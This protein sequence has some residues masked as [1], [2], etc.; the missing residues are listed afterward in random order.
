MKTTHPAAQCYEFSFPLLD[1]LARVDVS[2]EEVTIRAT[3]DTFN[4]VR[5][6]AFVRELIAE[7]FIP[8]R[9][10][11]FSSREPDGYLGVRWV[12]DYDWLDIP[13][14]ALQTARRFMFALLAGGAMLWAVLMTALFLHWLT[15]FP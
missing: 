4:A 2:G 12:V 11:W 6:A 7:G 14:E 8:E 13:P 9:C 5:R 10:R 3:R 15:P 1:T